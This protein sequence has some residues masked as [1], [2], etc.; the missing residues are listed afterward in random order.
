MLRLASV[1]LLLGAKI[2]AARGG[3]S[4]IKEAGASNH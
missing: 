4:F 3:F 1:A 2:Q